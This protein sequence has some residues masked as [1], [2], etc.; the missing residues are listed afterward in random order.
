MRSEERQSMCQNN[1]IIAGIISFLFSICMIVSISYDQ[2]DNWSLIICDKKHMVGALIMM[3]ILTLITYMI[4]NILYSKARKS[5]VKSKIQVNS[6]I[7][8]KIFDQH[9]VAVPWIILIVLWLPNYILYFPGCLTYDIIRQ[10][11]QF[12]SGNLTNHHPV[13]TTLF[14]GIFVKFGRSIGNQNAGIAV[15]LFFTLL[16][17]SGVFAICF[18]WMYKKNTTYWIRFVGLAFYGLFPI[19]SA[20]ARTAV[21]D[22][23]FYPIFVLFVLFIF[24]MVLEPEKIFDSKVKVI[25]FLLI[26]LLLCLVRHNGF[27]I[28]LF[29][30][31]FCILGIKKYRKQLIV[32]FIIMVAFWEV[33]QKAILPMAGVEPG[34]KQEMLSIPFQQTAR[35]VKYYEKD[36]STEEEKVIR[37]V[38]DYDTIG[39]NYDPDLSDPVKNTYKQKD[40]Y[41]PDYFKI[42][43]EMFQKHP[44]AYI[45]ATLNGTYGYW[46]YMTEVRYPYGY[47]VQPE[48][49]DI[50]QK[51]Y[52]IYYQKETKHIRDRYYGALDTIYQ[53]T[54][55]SLLTKPM[56]YLWILIGLFGMVL[57]FERTIRYWIAFVPV[58]TSFFICLASP[59][60][61]DMRYMLPI[62]ASTILY[63]AFVNE[64]LYKEYNKV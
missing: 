4:I 60:N 42:W 10:Y 6:R 18:Y 29:T 28:L 55:L 39:K 38:L 1:R 19:W 44:T 49:M 15:Y 16:L 62:T 64:A 47:Y 46:G 24:D 9:P 40:E 45:Q 58:M 8:E 11:E 43:V 41:L 56:I 54:P 53:K 17:T 7:G 34:G 57:S 5:F 26:S 51:E 12:F 36:V 61:G 13:L 37:Q 3:M 52:K 25:L 59:V 35:Y 2:R 50:Y 23:L 33:Y 27:Y 48:S 21:K 32:L 63:I 14:E 20:Y 22:T 31:P 30:M